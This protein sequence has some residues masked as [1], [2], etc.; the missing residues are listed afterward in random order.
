MVKINLRNALKLKMLRRYRK[1][2]KS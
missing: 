2:Q 1:S